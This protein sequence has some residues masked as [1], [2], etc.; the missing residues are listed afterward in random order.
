MEPQTFV[1]RRPARSIVEE[2]APAPQVAT[3]VE[4]SVA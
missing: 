4:E 1:D 2:T 3:F